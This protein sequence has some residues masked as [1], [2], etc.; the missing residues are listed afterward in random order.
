[1]WERIREILRKEFR[2]ALRE[3][4]MR[5]MLF[6]PAADPAHRLRLRR[7]PGR[8]KRRASPGWT[9]T[10]RPQSRELLAALRGLRPLRVCAPRRR[11]KPRSGRLL[12]HG[13]VQRRGPRAAR[14]RARP[15]ARPDRRRADPGGRHQL[16][17]RLA[18]FELRGPDRRGIFGRSARRRSRRRGS[19]RR[20]AAGARSTSACPRVNAAHAAS[21]STRTCAAATTSCPAWWSTSSCW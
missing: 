5:A 10:A 9:R 4:R 2:Q 3:P 16:Q 17:H 18:G 8:R 12:D 11:A 7:Q 20:G 6:V 21:G 19:W 13:D 15:R 1:M 14:L